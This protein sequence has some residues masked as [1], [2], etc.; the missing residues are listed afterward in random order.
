MLELA[1]IH[2]V[3]QPSPLAREGGAQRR[4][5]GWQIPSAAASI[6][7]SRKGRGLGLNMDGARYA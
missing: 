4:K 7:L 6:P 5:R 1:F 2:D 3:P